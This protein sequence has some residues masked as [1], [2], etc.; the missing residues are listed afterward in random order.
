MSA[1]AA[2]I[3]RLRPSLRAPPRAR[4]PVSGG[5]CLEERTKGKLGKPGSSSRGQR[6]GS[7][8]VLCY[9]RLQWACFITTVDSLIPYSEFIREGLYVSRYKE[10]DYPSRSA[11]KL[12]GG[13]W[14]ELGN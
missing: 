14:L 2:G 6:Q 13:G 12:T 1:K 11:I 4:A 3:R 10:L 5:S 7:R 9:W 8:L